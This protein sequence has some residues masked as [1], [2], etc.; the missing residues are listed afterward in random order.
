MIH[1]ERPGQ[2]IIDV[3]NGEFIAGPPKLLKP[4]VD[5]AGAKLDK[6][7]DFVVDC[8]KVH[9]LPNVTIH[10]GDVTVTI[11]AYDYVS[12]VSSLFYSNC[13]L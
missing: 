1:S 8:D 4:I 9:T 11:T 6:Y 13:F 12:K 10:F 2:A 3:W 5:L 7:K